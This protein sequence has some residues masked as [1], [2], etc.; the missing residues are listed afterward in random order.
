[1]R[2]RTH[3]HPRSP[4]H[5]TARAHPHPLKH[6]T[7]IR[8]TQAHTNTKKKSPAREERTESLARARARSKQIETGTAAA[9]MASGHCTPPRTA[10]RC[11]SASGGVKAAADASAETTPRLAAA[12]AACCVRHPNLLIAPAFGSRPHRDH[13]N[14]FLHLLSDCRRCSGRCSTIPPAEF[15]ITERMRLFG[16]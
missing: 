13:T 5:P 2:S 8:P 6:N 16:V 12:D 15:K 7:H 3:A 14:T 1:M 9:G 4:T 10:L 11:R